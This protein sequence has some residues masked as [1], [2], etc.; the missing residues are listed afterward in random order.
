MKLLYLGL[1]GIIF[2]GM[3]AASDFAPPEEIALKE[4]A[5]KYLEDGTDK[6]L[7]E[8]CDVIIDFTDKIEKSSHPS[9]VA[10]YRESLSGLAKT[11]SEQE[12]NLKDATKG[13]TKAQRDRLDAALISAHRAAARSVMLS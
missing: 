8:L 11:I 13:L 4:V 7:L 2:S 3:C 1:V 6:L 9:V 10:I 12:I 5:S